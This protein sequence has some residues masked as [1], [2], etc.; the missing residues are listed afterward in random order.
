MS[1]KVWVGSAT[2]LFQPR[3]NS[4]AGSNKRVT[5]KAE[6]SD[7]CYDQVSAMNA[8]RADAIEE[9]GDD[10]ELVNDFPESHDFYQQ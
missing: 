3:D 8:A 5:G 1:D 6:E 10:Y 9:A 2:F 4:G 7:N